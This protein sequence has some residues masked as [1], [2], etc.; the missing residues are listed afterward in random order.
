[1]EFKIKHENMTSLI[2]CLISFIAAFFLLFLNDTIPSLP[3]FICISVTAITAIL[4][5]AEQLIG[6]AI[7]ISGSE[8]TIKYFIG[9]RTISA[10]EICDI[11]IERFTRYR[12]GNPSY[13]EHRLRLIIKLHGGGT[14]RLTDKATAVKGKVAFIFSRHKPVEDDDVNLYQAY[15]AI[16]ELM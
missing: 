6:T 3:F 2:I 8:I 14:I 9:K 1:M 15:L 4:Y 10:Q 16:R 12:K 7:I 11:K 13:T 5:F